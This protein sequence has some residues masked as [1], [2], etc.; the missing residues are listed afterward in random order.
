[1][2]TLWSQDDKDK[3]YAGLLEAAER[4]QQRRLDELEDE[5]LAQQEQ[6][7]RCNEEAKD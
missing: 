4:V 5:R 6:A 3:F 2:P 1:M 7:K